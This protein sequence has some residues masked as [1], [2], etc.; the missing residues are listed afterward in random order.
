MRGLNGKI[1]IVTGGA[2]R[3]GRA[4]VA[5]LVSEGVQ[6]VVADIN[7]ADAQDVAALHGAM[8]HAIAFDAADEGSVR[9]LIDATVDRFGGLD[10]LHNNAAFVN[11]G[12]MGVDTTALETPLELWDVTMNVNVRGYFV[13]CAQAL[14]HMIARG[15][16]AIINT[17]SGSGHR[18]DD[19]RIAYGTSKG[20][21]STLTMYVAAQHGKQ[22]VRC[23]AIAP[24]LIADD[25]LRSLAPKLVALNERHNLLP[26]V[27][28]PDDI[29]SLVAFLASDEAAFITGQ[30]I[31]IDGGQSSHNPQMVEAM[32]M[33]SSYS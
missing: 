33:G 4:V 32:E 22:G 16:G 15:G 19:V 9:A 2:G 21:V 6:T 12:Q 20:A 23:N 28:V 7:K 17:S 30:I 3:I 27:G 5:R 8:A 24:G 31:S 25:R 11:L 13:A 26:R 18:G 10:I 14:P 29:A 1:A